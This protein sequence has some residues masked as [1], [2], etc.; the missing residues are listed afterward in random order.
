MILMHIPWIFKHED[1]IRFLIKSKGDTVLELVPFNIFL[2][3][4]HRCCINLYWRHVS[5]RSCVEIAHSYLFQ[6]NATLDCE[7]IPKVD[8]YKMHQYHYTSIIDEWWATF[9][10]RSILHINA[11]NRLRWRS[12]CFF[13]DIFNPANISESTGY[14]WT[15]S[16]TW[17]CHIQRELSFK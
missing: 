3:I 13:Q 7:H 16:I 6:G 9:C 1:A 17:K 11:M 14:W 12:H 5:I 8:R 10:I 2:C 15:K 4:L